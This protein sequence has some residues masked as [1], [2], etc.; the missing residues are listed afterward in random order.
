[1][2]DNAHQIYFRRFV[3]IGSCI[4][5]L[6]GIFNL[7]IDPHD[8]Y[9]LVS[10]NGMNANKIKAYKTVRIAKPYAVVRS[11]PETVILGTSREELGIDPE[12]ILFKFRPVYN[13]AMPGASVYELL[14][15]FQHARA[16][17]P[18]KMVLLGLEFSFF[19]LISAKSYGNFN[20]GRLF[21]DPPKRWPFLKMVKTDLLPTLFSL[22]STK[23]SFETIENQ[24]EPND[25]LEN[26]FID[27]DIML[28]HRVW[29]NNALDRF[30]ESEEALMKIVD[31]FWRIGDGYKKQYHPYE[32]L[33]EIIELCHRNNIKLFLFVPPTHIR[34]KALLYKAGLGEAF[35][36]WKKKIV[37]V[38]EN[39]ALQFGKPAF[40]LWDFSNFN[41]YTT[42]ELPRN[43]GGGEMK[44]HW[45]ISH[46]K[47]ELGDLMLQKIFS[48][49]QSLDPGV[50]DLGVSLN[51]LNIDA[52]LRKDAQSI[53]NYFDTHPEDGSELEAT[54]SK[55]Q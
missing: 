25:F 8:I 17:R 46:Y 11:R 2:L 26:G 21:V 14:K 35:A 32:N 50:E 41:P 55:Y 47:K 15:N 49:P 13:L 30:I 28:K 34:R 54:V 23:L 42:E 4:V 52:Y 39:V 36:D 12:N 16:L 24:K 3:A 10:V 22:E 6:I 45:E 33:R 40:P 51:L 48:S 7:V 31:N 9:R 5:L 37:T 27:A 1:M 29:N 38:N 43:T 53:Q 44:W 18:V 19:E 20:P